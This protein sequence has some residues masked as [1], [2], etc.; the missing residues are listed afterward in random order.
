MQFNV[1]SFNGYRYIVVKLDYITDKNFVDK[2]IS[3]ATEEASRQN[4]NSP[5]GEIRSKQRILDNNIAGFLAE[6]VVAEYIKSISS[7]NNLANQLIPTP[8]VNHPTHRDIKIKVNSKEKTLEVRSSFQISP[9]LKIEGILTWAFRLLGKYATSY[10]K[11]EADKD[12]YIT[13]IHRYRNEEIMQKITSK[14]DTLI[15]G[16]ASKE[17]F[18]EIGKDE[19]KGLKQGD[20][21]YRV[22][23]PINSAPKDVVE[24]FEEILEVPKESK[25]KE[26]VGSTITKQSTLF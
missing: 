9:H 13:V 6:E 22:I 14:V 2:V 24:L 23:S 18:E 5:A 10:K 16:G 20:A 25:K 12:Y 1:E 21:I 4:K 8:F 26:D 17:V 7:Q 19:N 3:R 15:I 11:E